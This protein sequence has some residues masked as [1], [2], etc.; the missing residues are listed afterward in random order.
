[1]PDLSGCSIFMASSTTSSCP[2]LT[3]LPSLTSTSTIAPSIGA[4]RVPVLMLARLL[5]G[6]W[7]R[8]SSCKLPG[9]VNNQSCPASS[10]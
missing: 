2:L 9:R 3:A 7:V 4:L 1:M 6:A 8:S 10:R 5:T